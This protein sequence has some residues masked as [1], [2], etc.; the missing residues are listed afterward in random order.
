MKTL[1][2]YKTKGGATQKYAQWLSEQTKGDLRKFD[3]IKKDSFNGYERI[4]VSSGTYAGLMPLNR[5]IKK[6]WKN[7]QEKEVVVV[8]VGAAP[9][10]DKWSLWSYNRIPEKI[11][12][13]IKYFKVMGEDP[14][15]ARPANYKS[16]VKKENLKPVFEVLN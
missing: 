15:N 2:C 13:K 8:A 4:I 11:R 12:T 7:I 3:E 1:I 14:E 9:A 5:F 6:N 10:D 16:K